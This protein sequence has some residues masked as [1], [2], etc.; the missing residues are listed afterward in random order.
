MKN[1]GKLA[2]KRSN[3]GKM[4]GFERTKDNR[5]VSIL[6]TKIGASCIKDR[7]R[8]GFLFKLNSSG[9]FPCILPLMQFHI[10]SSS[11]LTLPLGE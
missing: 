9:L 5:A 2:A 11:L 7:G 1:W 10:V 4:D 8:G 6:C 3:K